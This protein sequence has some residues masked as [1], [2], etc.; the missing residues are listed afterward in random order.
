LC[1]LGVE[2]PLITISLLSVLLCLAMRGTAFVKESLLPSIQTCP[3]QVVLS[4]L[5]LN[6]LSQE[7]EPEPSRGNKPFS[8]LYPKLLLGVII[9]LNRLTEGDRR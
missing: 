4:F 8:W 6:G 1:E 2:R 3:A 9:D 5:S 7:E